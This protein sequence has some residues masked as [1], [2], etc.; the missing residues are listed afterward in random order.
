[1][2]RHVAVVIESMAGGGAQQV[3]AGLLSHWV[4]SGKRVDLITLRGA[5][6]DAYPIPNQVRRLVLGGGRPSQGLI[7]AIT[8]NL[9]R[10]ALLRSALRRSAADTVVS[11]VGTMNSIVVLASIGLGQKIV[12]SER[13]DPRQQ[14]LPLSWRLLRRLT[15]PFAD[16]LTANSRA[17]VHALAEMGIAKHAIWVP[18]PLRIS[19][20]ADIAQK[21]G[22]T[23]LA[24][25]RLHPQKA[26]DILLHAFARA[27]PALPGWTLQILGSGPLERELRLLAEKLCLPVNF[28]G[29]VEDPFPYYRAADFFVMPSRYEGSPNA[30]WEA[31][32][33]GLPAIITDSMHGALEIVANSGA[34][35][36]CKSGDA[37][38][39]AEALIDV[40]SASIDRVQ[41]QAEAE[42]FVACFSPPQAYAAWDKVVFGS[43]SA[44]CQAANAAG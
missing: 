35:R 16:V 24:V 38:S 40:A 29:H 2:N 12:I 34:V 43:A 28:L 39:L 27:L 37:A 14:K 8:S 4:E 36:V 20:S 5:E 31:L 25:G 1:M 6:V 13:N 26:Y 9:G 41:L 30:L 11:F 33:C 19:A 32:S 17:A 44:A 7:S 10:L 42:Q 18:N 15:Y 3:V 22:P 21:A 23:I